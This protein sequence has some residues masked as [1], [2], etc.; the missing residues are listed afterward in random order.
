[1]SSILGKEYLAFKQVLCQSKRR[2]LDRK[3]FYNLKGY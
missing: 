2:A 1:M 3:S